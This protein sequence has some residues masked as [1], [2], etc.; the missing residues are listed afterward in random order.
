MNEFTPSQNVPLPALSA[1]CPD[2]G[3]SRAMRNPATVKPYPRDSEVYTVSP[4]AF[5]VK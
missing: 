4:N 3:A 5:E 2:K 1:L